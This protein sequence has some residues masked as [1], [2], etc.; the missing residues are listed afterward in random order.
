VPDP[1]PFPLASGRYETGPGMR[2]FGQAGQGFPAEA[3]HFHPDGELAA[4][5]AAKLAVLRRAAYECHLLAPGLTPAEE[6]D[7]RTALQ[8]AFRLVAKEHSEA[9]TIETDGVTLH[10]LGVRVTD[11]SAA[12]PGL[13]QI[14]DGAPELNPVAS[15]IREWL[16]AWEGLWRLGDALGLA[17]QEDLAIVRGP[18]TSTGPDVLQWLHVCLPSSWVPAEK[19]GRPCLGAAS[20]RG[21]RTEPMAA[22][23]AAVALGGAIGRTGGPGLLSGGA[24]DHAR[25][26]WPEPGTVHHSLLSRTPDRHGN[27]SV[28]AGTA[29]RH[30]KDGMAAP[31]STAIWSGGGTGNR[32]G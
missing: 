10:Q 14:S 29:G 21:T 5:L 27:R 12:A 6:S 1:I 4:T 19:I 8:L 24:P 23:A 17:V 3:G 11:W 26:P 25:I 16:L 2:R 28:A 20:G 13:E 9:V 18:D 30:P 22:P 15:G 31:A 32:S 7:L